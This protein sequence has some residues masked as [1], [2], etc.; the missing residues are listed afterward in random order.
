MIDRICNPNSIG[1]LILSSWF[2]S[3]SKEQQNRKPTRF[4]WSS[5]LLSHIHFISL[6]LHLLSSPPL[7]LL[8]E[9]HTPPS[10]PIQY[11]SSHTLRIVMLPHHHHNYLSTL[12]VVVIG[13]C[14]VK[15]F[16]TIPSIGDFYLTHH[17]I[18]I[19]IIIVQL[20]S[21]SP[22]QYPTTITTWLIMIPLWRITTFKQE[23]N[24][25]DLSCNIP[26]QNVTSRR[27]SFYALPQIL[28]FHSSLILIRKEPPHNHSR[29]T[30]V[31]ESVSDLLRPIPVQCPL[32]FHHSID[33]YQP[34]AEHNPQSHLLRSPPKHY[35]YVPVLLSVQH[36][37]TRLTWTKRP[38]WNISLSLVGASH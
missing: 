8:I 20:T 17:I 19:I 9:T 18:N 7:P 36:K 23:S 27:T 28:H 6:F 34:Q 11:S 5:P 12:V 22:L 10:A 30:I 31:H 21:S 15:A 26:L 16:V 25:K 24:R 3:W 4:L 33:S 35:L 1:H 2:N 14:L 13:L 38:R 29:E 37:G 32:Q